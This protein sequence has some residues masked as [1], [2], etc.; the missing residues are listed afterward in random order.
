MKMSESVNTSRTAPVASH[1]RGDD[2]LFLTEDKL[3][4]AV[5]LMFFAYR[6]F[7]S[8]PDRILEA[9]GYGRAHHR[10]LHFINRQSGISINSLLDILGIS[11]QSLNPVLRK[12]IADGLVRS[13]VGQRD[14]RQRNLY[15]TD[16]GRALESSLSTAQRQRMRAAFKRAGAEAVV[17]FRAV[18]NN[19]VDAK[20]HKILENINAG[21]NTNTGTN[22][23]TPHDE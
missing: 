4:Q 11:K 14:K 1:E 19:M 23:D 17:G 12:L 21:I 6:G 15:L 7:T 3:L 8:D 13:D 20:T 10:A 22:K 9:Y 18:L 5:E 2:L 16:T